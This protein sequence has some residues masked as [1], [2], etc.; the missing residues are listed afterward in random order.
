MGPIGYHGKELI[1]YLEEIPGIN[2]MPPRTN[3]AS[4]M[5]EV[6]AGIEEGASEVK[7][8]R[9]STLFSVQS[10][11]TDKSAEK[12]NLYNH[13]RAK[14]ASQ[15][16]LQPVLEQK[17]FILPRGT[18]GLAVQF[19]TVFMRYFRSYYRYDELKDRDVDCGI[20]II[21]TRKLW[22]KGLGM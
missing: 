18:V 21:R 10:V 19:W 12:P 8:L 9:R 4:W 14:R 15:V 13:Y 2:A 5:L 17:D 1:G 16:A 22:I 7:N 3:P 20:C 6:L 11:D